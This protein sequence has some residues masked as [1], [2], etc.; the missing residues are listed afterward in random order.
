MEIVMIENN[1]FA[2]EYAGQLVSYLTAEQRQAVFAHIETLF[3]KDAIACMK[4]DAQQIV[5]MR[6]DMDRRLAEM[7]AKTAV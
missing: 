1:E 2:T 7:D 4:A 6:A 3:D 5:E